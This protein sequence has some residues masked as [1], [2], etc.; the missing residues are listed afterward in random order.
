MA[1]S[2]ASQ[3]GSLQQKKAP[4]KG[5]AIQ[6]REISVDDLRVFVDLSLLLLVVSIHQFL[7]PFAAW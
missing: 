4:W 1:W 7:S 5:L 2:Q 6:L 3:V